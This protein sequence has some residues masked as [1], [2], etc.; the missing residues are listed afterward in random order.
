[1]RN[2]NDSVVTFHRLDTAVNPILEMAIQITRRLVEDQ[3][4]SVF[5]E[6]YF[7][8]AIIPAV[9]RAGQGCETIVVFHEVTELK[10]LE[11]VR[12]DFVANISHEL[13]TPLTSIKGYTETLLSDPDQDPETLKSFM[14]VIQR[15]V[16]NMTHLLEN[17]LHLARLESSETERS[18][19]PV[20]V[21]TALSVA[22]EVCEAMAG[23]KDVQASS[24]V[25]GASVRVQSTHEQ[26]VRVLVNLLE[27]AIKY[28]PK[29]GRIAVSA[30]DRGSEWEISV[31]DEGPGIPKQDQRRIFERFYRG[32]K[33]RNG[34][35][36][37]GTGLGLAIC[38]HIVLKHGGRIWVESPV[39]GELVGSVFRFSLPK[40][41]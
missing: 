26:L 36:V 37:S 19:G 34:L 31:Q 33:D 28:S 23:E 8:V 4:I 6:R 20:D 38:K 7:H 24:T 17:L 3:Q 32:E 21:Q 12:K 11:Q 16:N 29:G 9:F 15:N 13:R 1:M 30:A 10:R 39:P 22:W 25:P 40:A 2:R 14:G 35:K 5:Q 41:E 27:N 18:L